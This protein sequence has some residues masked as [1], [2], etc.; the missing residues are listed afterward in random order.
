MGY[1]F[2]GPSSNVSWAGEQWSYSIDLGRGH[3]TN[4][5][6]EETNKAVIGGMLS[7]TVPDSEVVMLIVS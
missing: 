5:A 1:D 7:L 4:G 2:A 3:F 6:I